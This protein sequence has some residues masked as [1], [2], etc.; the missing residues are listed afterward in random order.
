MLQLFSLFEVT[1][2]ASVD[3]AAVLTNGGDNCHVRGVTA[4]SSLDV[5][6][7]TSVDVAA[8]HILRNDNCHISRCHIGSDN[9]H[10]CV[11][12]LCITPLVPIAN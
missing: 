10:I 8:V 3:V 2:I 4:I 12:V 1:T 5:T 11:E 9:S 7:V 6:I